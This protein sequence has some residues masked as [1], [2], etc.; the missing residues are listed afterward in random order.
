MHSGSPDPLGCAHDPKFTAPVY[1]RLRALDGTGIGTTPRSL[2]IHSLLSVIEEAHRRA[3]AATIY[4]GG[5]PRLFGNFRGECTVG[6]TWV[7]KPGGTVIGQAAVKVRAADATWMNSLGSLMNQI[8][9]D[10]T[11]LAQRE[12]INAV[13]VNPDSK[14]ATHRLCDSG[15]PWLIPITATASLGTSGVH[16]GADSGSMHPTLEGQRAYAAAFQALLP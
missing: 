6:T 11:A 1:A 5:Y 2:P 8:V 15:T 10:E 9:S 4:V 3:P 13:Q 7:T 14:F 12:G 16:L